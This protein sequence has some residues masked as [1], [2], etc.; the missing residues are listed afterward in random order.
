MKL[1]DALMRAAF[2]AEYPAAWFLINH[3]SALRGL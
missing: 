1:I 2:P 3:L